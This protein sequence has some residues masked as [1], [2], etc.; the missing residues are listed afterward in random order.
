[1][2][3]IFRSI[4]SDVATFTLWSFSLKSLQTAWPLYSFLRIPFHSNSNDRSNYFHGQCPSQTGRNNKKIGTSF[5]NIFLGL[6]RR[7]WNCEKFSHSW[8]YLCREAEFL[9]GILATWRFYLLL[10][11]EEEFQLKKIAEWKYKRKIC[12]MKDNARTSWRIYSFEWKKING[13]NL[14]KRIR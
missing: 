10:R 12:T 13:I 14:G 4:I 2:P 3:T 5:G 8:K 9:G 11:G 7:M 6:L 1:M